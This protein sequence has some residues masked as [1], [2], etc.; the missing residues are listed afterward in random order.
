[1]E[2]VSSFPE[3]KVE[4]AVCGQWD[5]KSMLAHIAGRDI[6]FTMILRMLRVGKAVPY[7]G[8]NIEKYNEALVKE[9]EG[10]T[11]KEVRDEFVKASEGFLEEYGNLEGKLWRQRFWEQR[12]PTPAW[13]VEHSVEHYEEHME[14]IEKKLREWGR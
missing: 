10:K 2:T 9:R 7:R 13:V 6:Y 1:M 11:W 5:I 14:E 12:N 8:D 4:E 3:D